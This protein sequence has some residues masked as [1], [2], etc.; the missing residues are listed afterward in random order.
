MRLV[1]AALG[2]AALCLAPLASADTRIQPGRWEIVGKMDF[3]GMEL[4][5]GMPMGQPIKG[6][7]CVSE[8]EAQQV[9]DGS[10]P[11]PADSKCTVTD[12]SSSGNTMSFTM[13]CSGSTVKVD[14]TVQSPQ[15]YTGKMVTQGADPTQMMT[16]NFEGKRTGDACS[17]AEQAADDA[18][19]R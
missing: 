10:L 6:I 12:K 18:R 13:K 15:A 16:M 3:G 14:A 19:G 7:S 8:Q 9:A 5:P 11:V 2:I 1:V 4:P 17:A